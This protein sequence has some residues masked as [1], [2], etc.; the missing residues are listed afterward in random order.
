MLLPTIKRHESVRAA[1]RRR[2]GLTT[3]TRRDGKLAVKVAERMMQ[4]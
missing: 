3:L 4:R 1:V 2:L